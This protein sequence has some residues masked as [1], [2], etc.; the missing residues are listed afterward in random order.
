[1]Y[2]I[3]VNTNT[4]T[5]SRPL[6]KIA[7]QKFKKRTLADNVISGNPPQPSKIQVCGW[8]RYD[9]REHGQVS[10]PG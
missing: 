1:M 4:Y 10:I 9:H 7:V 8:Q 3:S 2:L 5:N 6:L